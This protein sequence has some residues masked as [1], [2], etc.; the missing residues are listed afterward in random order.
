[1][2]WLCQSVRAGDAQPGLCVEEEQE[3]NDRRRPGEV[4][5]DEVE[6]AVRGGVEGLAGEEG[7]DVVEPPPLGLP[8]RHEQGGPGVEAGEGPLLPVAVHAM[9]R[10]Y[11]RDPLGQGAGEHLHVLLTQDYGPVVVQCGEARELGAERTTGQA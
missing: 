2:N 8:L 3:V 5:Q 11:L 4:A 10:E 6:S 1:M 7:E 9:S